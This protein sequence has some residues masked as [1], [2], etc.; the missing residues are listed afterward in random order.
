MAALNALDVALAA[1][2]GYWNLTWFPFL[3]TVFGLSGDLS[4][5][6]AF[7]DAPEEAFETQFE[8]EPS[9]FDIDAW[10]LESAK[11]SFHKLFLTFWTCFATHFLVSF[12][13]ILIDL[14][15]GQLESSLFMASSTSL[16]ISFM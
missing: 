2:V 13:V 12:C 9:F 14:F 11:D 6:E 1:L 4:A 8:H 16:L 15:P 3:R 5:P 7:S 10:L